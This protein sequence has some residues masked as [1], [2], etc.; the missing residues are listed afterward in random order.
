MA[1]TKI[2][3]D[4]IEAAVLWREAELNLLNGLNR[5]SFP[6]IGVAD[7]QRTDCLENLRAA[8]DTYRKDPA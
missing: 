8:I 4:L 2:P 7:K 3:S 6:A 1:I 5:V